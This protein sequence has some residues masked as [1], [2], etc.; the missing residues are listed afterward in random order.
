M[1]SCN[2][3][4]QIG[5]QNSSAKTTHDELYPKWVLPLDF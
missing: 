1:G 4:V 5:L 3:Q 2:V